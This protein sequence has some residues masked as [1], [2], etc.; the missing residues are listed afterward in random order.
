[1]RSAL[2]IVN[3]SMP[4]FYSKLVYCKNKEK[5][6]KK[7]SIFEK[8]GSFI[9]KS[10]NSDRVVKVL[11]PQL[12]NHQKC[13]LKRYEDKLKADQEKN[14]GSIFDGYKDLVEF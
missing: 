1:M 8:Y 5:F 3:F 4:T 12:C 7:T 10:K 9:R 11:K 14:M 6:E 2:P 13:D